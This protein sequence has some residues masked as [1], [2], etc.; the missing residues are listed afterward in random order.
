LLLGLLEPTQGSAHVLGYDVSRDAAQIREKSGALLEHDGLYERLTAL[1]NLEF[2]ARAWH[3][4]R[5][6]RQQRARELLERFGLWE[7]RKDAVNAW[8]RGMKRK[9]ALARAL[10]HRPAVVF[11]DEP[12]A[13]LDPGSAAALRDDLAGLA[14]GEGATIF[15]NTHN[16]AEAE[17]LCDVVGVI[18]HGKL[19]ALGRPAELRSQFEGQRVDIAGSG[20]QTAW[21]QEIESLPGI[22]SAELREH[23]IVLTLTQG[24]AA[25]PVVRWLVE[26]GANVEE[27]RR[28]HAT[29]EDVYLE[30]TERAE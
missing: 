6:A 21:Q 15:L 16:L 27:V 23:A 30:L 11:L 7:R 26:H 10:L 2:Y 29:L 9:L 4:P 12:T 28:G 8:S 13:G 19:I 3:L 25:A 17:R 20:F 14:S 22:E 1:D 18:T 5:A 24:G